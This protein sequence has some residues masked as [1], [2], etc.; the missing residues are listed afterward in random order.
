MTVS[1]RSRKPFSLT[2]KERMEAASAAALAGHLL[3]TIELFSGGEKLTSEKRDEL[4]K[5][6]AAGEYVEL[7]LDITA[8]E[9]TADSINRNYVRIADN[10]M[11]NF[12]KTLIGKPFLRD[13]SQYNSLNVGGKI[14]KCEVLDLGG[15]HQ[16]I[17][18]SVKITALWLVDLAL[19]DLLSFV[20]V[21]W[22]AT[23]PVH[24]SY[25]KVPILT[26]CWHWPGDKFSLV[27][28]KV[29]GGKKLQYDRNG[30]IKI[31][32]IYQAVEGIETSS[33]PVPAVTSAKIDGIRLSL[34]A[35]HGIEDDPRAQEDQIVRNSPAPSENKK[36]EKT[37]L[38]LELEA[39]V[40]RLQKLASFND[41]ERAFFKRLSIDEQASFLQ[42]SAADR[43]AELAPVYTSKNGTIYDKSHDPTSIALARQLDEQAERHEK[44]M[45]TA[46]NAELHARADAELKHLPGTREERAALLGALESIKDEKHREFAMSFLSA[47]EVQS[48]KKFVRQGAGGGKKPAVHSDDAAKLAA[49]VTEYMK[50]NP[51]VGE[52]RDMA[53]GMLME[54]SEEAQE[55]YAKIENE[56]AD[57]R[58]V[59][60]GADP[61]EIEKIRAHHANN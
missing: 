13:H 12:A 40:K 38:E 30:A 22:M 21:S 47:T 29:G 51:D 5:K 17:K 60:Q 19:R 53:M 2:E 54:T 1:L 57:R 55:L 20:S 11:E 28:D 31:Q 6:C 34:S 50:N 48:S 14:E 10:A 41:R 49:L 15:G 35:A 7:H 56:K 37:P 42:L 3:P 59:Q 18:Q 9:Q 43:A 39:Q 23:G 25:C 58:L 44:D 33:V 8:Y 61:D 4:L 26:K 32:W 46:R 24:C 27:E 52:D 36:M 16:K 45:S